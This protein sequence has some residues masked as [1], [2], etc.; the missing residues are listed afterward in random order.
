[1]TFE[2]FMD[3][4]DELIPDLVADDGTIVSFCTASTSSDEIIS[5]EEA[6]LLEKFIEVVD[7]P[8]PEAEYRPPTFSEESDQKDSWATD[9]ELFQSING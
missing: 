7:E 3:A 1:M 6:E 4:D 2:E 5:P 9:E 8:D